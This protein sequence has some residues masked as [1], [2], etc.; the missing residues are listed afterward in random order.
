MLRLVFE[1]RVCLD[2][3]SVFRRI[4]KE[5][6]KPS[7]RQLGKLSHSNPGVLFEYVS[8]NKCI[9]NVML[10]NSESNILDCT[11]N[12]I[13]CVRKSLPQRKII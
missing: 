9:L 6:V 8:V 5:N 1:V 4:S 10:N 3:C 12:I 7:G 2:F 13:M 11:F